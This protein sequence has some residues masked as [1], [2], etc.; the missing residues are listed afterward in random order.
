MAFNR[1]LSQF[2]AYLELDAAG[3][4]IGITPAESNTNVGI[5]V[6]NPTSKLQVQGD[7][8]I[9]GVTTSTGGF[10]GDL[11]GNAD[12]AS[13]LESSVTISLE[14]D[15]AGSISFDGS[16][17]VSIAATIQPNS[18]A[19]GDDTTGNYVATLADAGN[20]N[21]TISNSGSEN[22]EVTIDL[23]DTTVSA[24][25]YG[26][27]SEIPTFTVDAKG[28][29]TA[30]GTAAVSTGMTVTGDSG[31]ED[32]DLLTESLSISGGTNLTSVAANNG[33]TVNLDSD[34][35]LDNV[36]ATGIIT[37]TGGFEGDLTGNA[38]TATTLETSEHLK[39]L[40]MLLLLQLVLMEVVM[41]LLLQLSNQIRLL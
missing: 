14:G 35:N 16:Q 31:S 1:D 37:A 7:V 39:S 20:S 26:S 28:R 23:A 18:V 32:I 9:S 30:A 2:A 33:V 8:S 21:L 19:L 13:A 34:I 12:T 36:N 6:T 25:S 5:G 10:V 15:V 38:D 29:L 24:G 27:S 4:Y 22:A 17:N 11:T 41:F 40:E 3:N